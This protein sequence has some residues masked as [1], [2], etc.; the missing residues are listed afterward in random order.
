MLPK[1]EPRP[2]PRTPLEAER[3][4]VKH[5]PAREAELVVAKKKVAE[6]KQ[7]LEAASDAGSGRVV[8]RALLLTGAPAQL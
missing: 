7:W 3:W 6:L 2:V 1:P 4:G 5:A 8:C